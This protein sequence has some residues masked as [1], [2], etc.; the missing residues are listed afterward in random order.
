M[1]E[2][3]KILKSK[4]VVD[5]VFAVQAPLTQILMSC[6]NFMMICVQDSLTFHLTKHDPCVGY[7]LARILDIPNRL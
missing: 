6:R 7:Y 4:Q 3:A 2:S 5:H 1:A